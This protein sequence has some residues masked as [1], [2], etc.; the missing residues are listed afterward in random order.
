MAL[1]GGFKYVT[2]VDSSISSG[3][4]KT[5]QAHKV[6]DGCEWTTLHKPEKIEKI[7]PSSKE[8][9]DTVTVQ[10]MRSLGV[11]KVRGKG[12]FSS[13]NPR[14]FLARLPRSLRDSLASTLPLACPP[15]P[16]PLNPFDMHIALKS[17]P[18]FCC[19][20]QSRGKRV[21]YESD[22]EEELDSGVLPLRVVRLQLVCLFC[23]PRERCYFCSEY[24][25]RTR[26]QGCGCGDVSCHNCVMTVECGCGRMCPACTK[27][28]EE[29]EEFN[30]K[31]CCC[32]CEEERYREEAAE[33]EARMEAEEAQ[34]EV[35][36]LEEVRRREVAE[37]GQ[38]GAER[39]WG[40]ARAE[41][42]ARVRAEEEGQRQRAAAEALRAF[43]EPVK[44]L[45]RALGHL[46]FVEKFTR[47]DL[48]TPCFEVRRAGRVVYDLC[49]QRSVPGVG[50]LDKTLQSSPKGLEAARFYEGLLELASAALAGMEAEQVGTEGGGA[51]G[52]AGF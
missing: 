25:P 2:S 27:F 13:L 6:P 34:R 47:Q 22:E 17:A 9:V 14:H 41:E 10:L 32:E 26:S 8:G 44:A 23:V 11:E 38:E 7:F 18:P 28:C 42:E 29:C 30:C 24:A 45:D 52:A 43:S 40:A 5:F 31:D 35:E 51:A 33:A 1:E 19:M 50:A 39:K 16:P 12:T 46:R 20:C 49:L 3:V 36:R 15:W 37:L 21:W 48:R 4:F